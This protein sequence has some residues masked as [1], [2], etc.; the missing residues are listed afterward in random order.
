MADIF[1]KARKKV[2]EL[3]ASINPS[4]KKAFEDNDLEVKS[5]QVDKQLFG[6]GEKADGSMIRPAYSP[7]T[8]SIKR[9]KGQP[10][11]RVTLKDSGDFYQ[12]I[13]VIAKDDELEITTSI[14]YAKYLFKKYGDNVLGIQEELMRDFLEKHILGQ[15]KKDLD[16]IIA[17]S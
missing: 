7:I 9:K 17:K 2:Q 3:R 1:D 6:K 10:I 12:S 5:I 15:I 4:I 14:S 13:K 16:G 11:N 8:V